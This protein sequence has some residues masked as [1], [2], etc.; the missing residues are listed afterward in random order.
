[1]ETSE[2]RFFAGL[3]SGYAKIRQAFARHVGMSG[4]RLMVLMRLWR[5]GETSHSELRRL[6]ALDGASVTRLVKE[7][8]AEG[9]LTRRVDPG[10]NRYTLARL[11]PVG[12]RV[13]ADLARR[14]QD[15]QVRLLDGVT[16]EEREAVLR[17]LERLS[18]N[19]DR[20]AAET[21]EGNG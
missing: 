15:Y 7:F 17:A 18:S 16:P 2:D 4:P 12:E 3:G 14:H 20:I 9:M 11:T 1:M 10:D 8:E 13:A 5:T 19:A 6:L 21:Q